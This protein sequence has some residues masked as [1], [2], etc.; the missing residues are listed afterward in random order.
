MQCKST[1]T[2]SKSTNSWK[3]L[4]IEIINEIKNDNVV[5]DEISDNIEDDC[6]DLGDESADRTNNISIIVGPKGLRPM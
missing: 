2:K 1:N 3:N 6:I 4:D 5:D